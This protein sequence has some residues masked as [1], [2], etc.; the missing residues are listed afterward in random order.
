MWCEWSLLSGLAGAEGETETLASW[1]VSYSFKQVAGAQ[2][3]ALTNAEEE[4]WAGH[5]PAMGKCDFF[6]P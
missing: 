1:C 5:S 2:Q 6:R 3:A 4:V